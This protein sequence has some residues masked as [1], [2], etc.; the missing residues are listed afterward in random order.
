MAVE[1]KHLPV[2]VYLMDFF[3]KDNIESHHWAFI[4]LLFIK[5]IDRFA[6][7]IEKAF[8]LGTCERNILPSD[9]GLEE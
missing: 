9:K 6:S 5:M 2:D 8:L 7:N 3:F 4:Y 1:Y